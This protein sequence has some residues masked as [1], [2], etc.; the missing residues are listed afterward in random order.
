MTAQFRRDRDFYFD[1]RQ[2]KWAPSKMDAICFFSEFQKF[3]QFS[4]EGEWDSS[5]EINKFW[6]VFVFNL[7]LQLH[8]R[9]IRT[10]TACKSRCQVALFVCVLCPKACKIFQCQTALVS[11]CE[12]VCAVFRLYIA[13]FGHFV[14]GESLQYRVSVYMFSPLHGNT[15]TS[16]SSI[17]LFV[18][19]LFVTETHSEPQRT[20]FASHIQVFFF[21]KKK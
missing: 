20:F 7:N 13:G 4:R 5:K 11:T 10:H 21:K 15:R 3:I 1:H 18:A 19:A 17:Y 12:S 16:L 8:C 9:R 2:S 14:C 6:E